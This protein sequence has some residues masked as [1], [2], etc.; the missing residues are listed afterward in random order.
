MLSG[1]HK[2]GRTLEP[3]PSS[4]STRGPSAKGK[5]VGSHSGKHCR[6]GPDFVSG[7]A[8]RAA[9]ADWQRPKSLSQERDLWFESGSLQRRVCELSVP[10]P[11]E[12]DPTWRSDRTRIEILGADR[13]FLF[14]I[15]RFE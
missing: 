7:S 15:E 10:T 13:A 1:L 11:G 3:G 8:F 4:K 9:V 5:A 12:P 14:A 6:F 2:Q